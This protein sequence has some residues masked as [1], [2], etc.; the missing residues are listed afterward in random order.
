MILP[1]VSQEHHQGS[2]DTYQLSSS[3]SPSSSTS[4]SSTESKADSPSFGSPSRSVFLT[5]VVVQ[6]SVHDAARCGGITPWLQTIQSDPCIHGKRVTVTTLKRCRFCVHPG[7]AVGM[8]AVLQP[9]RAAFH[10]A[11]EEMVVCTF[12]ELHGRLVAKMKT[13]VALRLILEL[14]F[15]KRDPHSSSL[16]QTPRPVLSCSTP[17]LQSEDV[18]QPE[19]DKILISRE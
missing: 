6:R 10:L 15:L 5:V 19:S 7:A 18:V 12:V 13:P 17:G 2:D 9:L 8:W 4:R 3:C 1:Q 16:L 14:K 11:G